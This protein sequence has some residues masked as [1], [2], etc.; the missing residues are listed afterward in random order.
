MRRSLFLFVLALAVGTLL[1]LPGTVLWGWPNDGWALVA[2]VPLA[3]YVVFI[4]LE[5][6]AVKHRTRNPGTR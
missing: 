4:S 2:L 1:Y 5:S 3:L 6:A